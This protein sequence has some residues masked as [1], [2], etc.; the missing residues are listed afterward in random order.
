MSPL[1]QSERGIGRG[2]VAESHIEAPFIAGFMVLCVVAIFI[3]HLYVQ[4]AS[5]TIALAVSLIVFGVTLV[6]VDYGIS[7]LLMAML[8]SPEIEAG[9]VGARNERAL[10]LRYDDVL[11]AIIFFGVLIKQA[12][13]GRP[14]LL[15][16][17]PIN[18][19]IFA[20]YLV[21]IVSTLAALQLSVGAGFSGC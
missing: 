10:N 11:I 12:F 3:F 17:N 16:H 13:E 6:R 20:Y 9:S 15:R 8:L 14:I 1:I 7:I 5:Y 4:N 18:L 21:C 19:G 2:E